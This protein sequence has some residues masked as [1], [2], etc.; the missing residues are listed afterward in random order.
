MTDRLP[1]G[2]LTHVAD[3]LGADADLILHH[4]RGDSDFCSLCEDY[5]AVLGVM[6]RLETFERPLVEMRIAEYRALVTNLED[7]IQRALREMRR[8]R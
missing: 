4:A 8:G 6:R 2:V 7:E 5:A 1:P 3:R